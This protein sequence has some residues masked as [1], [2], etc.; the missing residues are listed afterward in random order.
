MQILVTEDSVAIF[1]IYVLLFMTAT[2]NGWYV[3]YVKSRH[4][5][6]VYEALKDLSIDAFLPILNVPSR[7]SDRKVFIKKALF[8]SYVFVK[9]NSL[10]DLH[11]SLSI[12]GACKYIRFGKEYAKVLDEEIKKINLMLSNNYLTEVET[13]SENLRIGEIKTI[14]NG[15]LTG[16]E[17]EIMNI[18]NTNRIIVRINSLQKNIIA[19]VPSYYFFE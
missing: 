6:K 18:N 5:E 19:T 4:E 12:S 3:L 8:P 11:R 17:C 10:L 9:I 13:N 1:K 16:L 14:S 7:R 2:H 15:A